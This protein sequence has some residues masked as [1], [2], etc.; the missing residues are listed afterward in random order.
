MNFA[1][2][3]QHVAGTQLVKTHVFYSLVLARVAVDGW[4]ELADVVP[5]PPRRR[6]V[7]PE[8]ENRLLKL[9]DAL[10][11]PELHP[12]YKA[13]VDASS[14]RT[15]VKSQREIRTR[16]LAHEMVDI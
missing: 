12:D 3:L 15:N 1:L 6:K 8:A 13:F 4:R 10:D 14:E 7:V 11:E 9:A 2:S 5:Q 16:I